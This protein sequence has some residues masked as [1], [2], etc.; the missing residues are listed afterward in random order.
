VALE[1]AG[2]GGSNG[3]KISTYGCESIE[4]WQFG[5]CKKN[6]VNKKCVL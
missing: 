6:S 3:G 5:G 4:L 1:R 2:D